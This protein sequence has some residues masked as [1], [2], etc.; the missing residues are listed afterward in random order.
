MN[1]GAHRVLALIDA[2]GEP[3]SLHSAG[4]HGFSHERQLALAVFAASGHRQVRG[5]LL[6]RVRQVPPPFFPK[7]ESND[8]THP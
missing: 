3:V 1:A 6:S 5:F 2:R 8:D 4:T 7:K